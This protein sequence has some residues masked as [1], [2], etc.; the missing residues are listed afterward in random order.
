MCSIGEEHVRAVI[1]GSLKD[2]IS[3]A[4]AGTSFGDVESH[5]LFFGRVGHVEVA[6]RQIILPNDPGAVVGHSVPLA[7]QSE[8]HAVSDNGSRIIWEDNLS[9][10]HLY[11]TDT[12]KKQTVRLDV[13]E[14]GAGGGGGNAIF[15]TASNDGSHVFFTDGAHLTV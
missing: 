14:A 15:Q 11:M 8:R 6:A 5:S 7:Q 13:A 1:A 12:A 4:T 2:R 9:G 10:G 3:S